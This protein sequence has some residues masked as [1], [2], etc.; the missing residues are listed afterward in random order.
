MKIS[1]ILFFLLHG[2]F[3]FSQTIPEE[4]TVDWT[5]AGVADTST[6]SF[7]TVVMSDYGVS[8]DSSQAN[9]SLLGALLE[10][11]GEQTIF[12]F[13]SGTFLFND[14]VVLSNGQVIRGEGSEETHFVFDQG[15][16]GHSFQIHGEGVVSDTLWL[17]DA[18]IKDQGFLVLKDASNLRKTDWLHLTCIDTA[19]VTSSWAVGSVGQMLQ[20]T[21]VQGDTLF[22]ASRLRISIAAS[23]R[24]F[25][26]KVNMIENV[27][28]ACLS[29]HRVDNTAPQQSSNISFRHAA[30]SW[31]A[32]V[33]SNLCTFSHVAA[34]FASNLAIV[35]SYFHHGH[36]YGGG[37][38]AYGVMLQFTSGEILV[39]NNIFE[40]LRHAM[41]VQ[42]GANG[43]VFAYNLSEDPF[44]DSSPSDAAGDMVLHGNYPFSNL[45]EQNIGHNIII[46]NS[47]GPN[48]PDNL[49]FRN[50]AKS[51]GIFFSAENSPNQL[52]VGN[53]VTNNGFPYRLVNYSIL[54]DGHFV[55]GNNNKG[56]IHPAGTELLQE[57]SYY[58]FSSPNFTNNSQ[59]GGVGTPSTPNSNDIPAEERFKNEDYTFCIEEKVVGTPPL[60]TGHSEPLFYPN[61]VRR[62]TEVTISGLDADEYI[63]TNQ[64]G[65]Q[66]RVQSG[67]RI[68]TENLPVGLYVVWVVDRFSNLRPIGKVVV[69][70]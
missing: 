22:L 52:L 15:G 1:A 44:W 14:P 7:Q 70:K 57:L 5:Q 25:V 54:G 28:I 19:W 24:P 60:E 23:F 48:G 27:G 67:K 18:T 58:I 6:A 47:H 36:D 41:I 40:R 50:R 34:S 56:E 17:A 59:Y 35:R 39:E 9:D 16:R 65:K 38:R 2:C 30:N 37:G 51:F 21:D 68:S 46:D 53:E 29:I 64:L 8:A 32:G 66:I 4:R 11:F 55:H 45:F 61:P 62:G 43:N 13:P 63:L 3:V 49:M 20:I 31:V 10:A 42:A 26:R 33:E 69:I 12:Q